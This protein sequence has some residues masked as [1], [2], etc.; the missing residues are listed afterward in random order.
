[1]VI[2]WGSLSC[3]H[4]ILTPGA[5]GIEVPNCASWPWS[6][7]SGESGE[8]GDEFQTPQTV[9]TKRPFVSQVCILAQQNAHFYQNDASY[10]N[11]MYS[12][13]LGPPILSSHA[14]L[15]DLLPISFQSRP[16][17]F[18]ISSQSRSNLVPKWPM[19]QWALG[20][21]GTRL[22][23]DWDEIWKIFGRHWNEIGM[24]YHDRS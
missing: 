4:V 20:Y 18:Q 11:R 6:A 10:F 8:S 12:L 24:I 19:G 23:R 13:P 14:H 15:G 2:V 5:W 17:I 22:E 16:N 9:S 21:F 3:T 1:M 7:E